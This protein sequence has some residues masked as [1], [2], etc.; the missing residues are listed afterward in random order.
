MIMFT[1]LNFLKSFKPKCMYGNLIMIIFFKKKKILGEIYPHNYPTVLY[2]RKFLKLKSLD[3]NINN[4]FM[5]GFMPLND[6]IK[7]GLCTIFYFLNYQ[8]IQ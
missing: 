1:N 3:N 2:A 5:S 8:C 6:T 7:N 4:W